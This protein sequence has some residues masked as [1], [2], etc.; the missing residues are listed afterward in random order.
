MLFDWRFNRKILL[1]NQRKKQMLEK[2]LEKKKRLLKELDKV[3][4]LIALEKIQLQNDGGGI[5]RKSSTDFE[6]RVRAKFKIT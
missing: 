3:S 2:L 4:E 1:K 6:K 5:G